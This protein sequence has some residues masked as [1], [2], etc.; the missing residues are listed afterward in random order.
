MKRKINSNVAVIIPTLNEEKG[1]GSTLRKLIDVLGSP[2]LILIDGNSV[3]GTVK[4]VRIVVQK[5]YSRMVEARVLLY[6][7]H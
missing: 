6:V 5:L 3:D 7:K 1:V 4:I 2:V